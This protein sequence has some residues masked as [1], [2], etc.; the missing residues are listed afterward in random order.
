MGYVTKLPTAGAASLPTL[1]DIGYIS[2]VALK[3]LYLINGGSGL[4]DSSGQGATL[5]TVHGAAPTYGSGVLPF[6][7]ASPVQLTTGVTIAGAAH[8][9]IVALNK[10]SNPA[11]GMVGMAHLGAALGGSSTGPM[12][13]L[14]PS[15]STTGTQAQNW[16]L[17]AKRPTVTAGT[18]GLGSW[19]I[20]TLV[21]D[22]NRVGLSLD[23]QAPVYINYDSADGGANT[24]AAVVIGDVSGGLRHLNADL[25]FFAHWARTLSDGEITSAYKAVRRMMQAKGLVL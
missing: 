18:N 24:S 11:N 22:A 16:G 13:L 23:G 17:Q 2:K 21:R 4:A 8:T 12:T 1:G 6:R 10:V 19:Q 15:N 7:S 9:V 3:G 25:G 5:T 14:I 20:L